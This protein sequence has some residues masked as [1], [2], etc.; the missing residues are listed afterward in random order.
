ML[1]KNDFH[2]VHYEALKMEK[3]GHVM[4]EEFSGKGSTQKLYMFDN[5]YGASVIQGFMSW[6]VP[7]LAVIHFNNWIKLRRSKKKRLKKKMLKQAGGF[8]LDY[9][10]PVT[11]D[12]KRY[13]DHKE[14]QRDLD[15]ISKL[16]P[17]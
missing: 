4:P 8:H 15:T 12:I 5:G 14:L 3:M 7:E 2:S 9:S 16:K 1:M 17:M 11:S 13:T 10:T 6:G